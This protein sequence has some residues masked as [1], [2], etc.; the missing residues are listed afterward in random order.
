[1]LLISHKPKVLDEVDANDVGRVVVVRCEIY[2]KLR[3]IWSWVGTETD[4]P[5]MK[6]VVIIELFD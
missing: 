4:A 2:G 3:C 1:L 6:T 5:V